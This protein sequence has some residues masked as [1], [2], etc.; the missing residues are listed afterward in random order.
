VLHAHRNLQ[1]R[2]LVHPLGSGQPASLLSSWSNRHGRQARSATTGECKVA[3]T[4]N[5]T[6][7]GVI[8]TLCRCQGQHRRGLSLLQSTMGQRHT[9]SHEVSPFFFFSVA[10][11][12][13][14]EVDRAVAVLS[15]RWCQ[16]C[17]WWRHRFQSNQTIGSDG[18][19]D[20]SNKVIFGLWTN[21]GK[22]VVGMH[23]KATP[24]SICLGS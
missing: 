15:R 17:G 12:E 21:M 6:A 11:A 13:D 10:A 2:K 5:T 1:R 24:A 22:N 7:S 20:P 23:L 19:A 8:S 3:W 4:S 9:T 16:G 14:V 18:H